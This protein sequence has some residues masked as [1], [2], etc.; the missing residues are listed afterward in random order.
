MLKYINTPSR[1]GAMLTLQLSLGKTVHANRETYS[2]AWSYCFMIR[3]DIFAKGLFLFAPKFEILSLR[4]AA[5]VAVC[6]TI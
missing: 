1:L 5:L 4:S 3:D 6:A 2:P